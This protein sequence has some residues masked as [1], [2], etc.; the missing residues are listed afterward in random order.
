M[1]CDANFGLK[2]L[3]KAE[4]TWLRS[5]A[6]RDLRLIGLLLHPGGNLCPFLVVARSYDGILH[7]RNPHL[8]FLYLQLISF[9]V[10]L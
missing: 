2:A 1:F 5:I 9:I 7:L 8:F 10:I 6:G 3:L 4:R